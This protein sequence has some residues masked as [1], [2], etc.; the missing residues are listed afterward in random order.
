MHS[1]G[2]A[3]RQARRA[4]HTRM[5][6]A[7]AL[8]AGARLAAAQYPL[9]SEREDLRAVSGDIWSVV[10]S[11]I[12]VHRG[13][14]VPTVATLG[15]IGIASR[16][17]STIHN[18]MSTHD[19]TGVMRLVAPIREGGKLY[20]FE[21]GSGQH[22]LPLSGAL[23]LAGRMSRSAN[24]RDA[25][26]G[27][28]AGHLTSLALRMVAYSGV[29]RARPRTTASPFQ[30]SVPGSSDWSK[31]SFFSGHIANSMACASFVSHRYS[32][33]FAEPLAFTYSAAIGIGRMADGEHWAS[34][35]MT[36]AIVGFAIGKAIADRQLRRAAA[37][38]AMTSTASR[39]GPQ[40]PLFSW[41]FSV[42][43]E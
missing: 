10:S 6:L 25:G 16:L 39:R 1:G 17:D 5:M 19:R 41:S 14:V 21:L 37:T 24:L 2:A 22:L 40:I 9:G 20:T 12:H 35:T 27:C 3:V 34:D 4:W 38:P 29:T 42:G 7:L 15:A 8:A 33:G 18:W 11:P 23:Y 26:L 30:V 13:D 31:Q 28:A 43:G 36:G 32:L